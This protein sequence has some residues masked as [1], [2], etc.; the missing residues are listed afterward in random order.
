MR[1]Y[2]QN[3]QLSDRIRRGIET[4]KHGRKVKRVSKPVKKMLKQ[5]MKAIYRKKI[6]ETI[7]GKLKKEFRVSGDKKVMINPGYRDYSRNQKRTIRNRLMS[8]K[9]PVYN[10][11]DKRMEVAI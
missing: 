2:K 3:S 1:L 5:Q 6:V 7:R 11:K 8:G 10:P 9:S 4:D